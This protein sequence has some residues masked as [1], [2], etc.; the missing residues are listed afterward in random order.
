MVDMKKVILSLAIVSLSL[1]GDCFGM[2]KDV[3]SVPGFV[4]GEK[5]SASCTE[6]VICYKF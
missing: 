6:H 3:M 4:Q 1:S 5:K 2:Q